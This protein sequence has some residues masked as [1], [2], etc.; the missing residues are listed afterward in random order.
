MEKQNNSG[1]Y[2]AFIIVLV[3]TISVTA[4]IYTVTRCTTDGKSVCVDKDSQTF[5]IEENALIQV[6]VESKSQGDYLIETWNELHPEHVGAVNYV[7]S[8]PLTLEQLINKTD[9]FDVKIVSQNDAAYFI[10]D[11]MDLG[12]RAGSLL[13]QTIPVLHQD[14]INS[15]GYYFVAN[16]VEGPLFVYNKTLMEE[17]GFDTID[18]D[19]SGLPDVFES[20]EKIMDSALTIQEN[21]PVIFPLTFEDQNM[22]YPFLTAGRWTLNFTQNGSNPEFGSN[23]F[24]EGLSFIESMGNVV[25]DYDTAIDVPIEV[26]NTPGTEDTSQSLEDEGTETE[27]IIQGE[28]ESTE[29]IPTYKVNPSETL[30]WQYESA[31]F[32]GKTL[33][34]IANDMKL[35]DMYERETSDEYVYAPFPSYKEHRL[36]PVA[37]TTGYV[38]SATSQFPSAAAEAIRILR[39]GES[40]T[41][42]NSD[43]NKIPS[44]HRNY[45]GNLKIESQKDLN[46][47]IA[48]G[49]SDTLPVTALNNNPEVL[50]RS[51]YKEVD[52]MQPIR[53]LY[54][55]NIT[56][57]EARDEILVL[58]QA[59]IEK[60]DIIEED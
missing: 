33:F 11:F 58:I 37:T 57:S 42:Y 59:W 45:I 15:R 53:D 56:T 1:L 19:K 7:V 44:Y 52:I 40:M 48:Y 34:S 4:Y 36:T 43:T 8:T 6:Q 46:K 20:W 2:A 27:E 41:I 49:Y 26:E 31:F 14:S 17:L 16:S 47:V 12:R 50:S 28:E 60:N 23:E 55:G 10:N 3:F 38:I 22:F 13:G 5:H 32:E 35:F 29:P 21:I 9:N 25:W 39:T 30:I 54:D 51:L 18:S 24:L